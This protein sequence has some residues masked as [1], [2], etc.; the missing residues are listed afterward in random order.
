MRTM[1][2]GDVAVGRRKI[3]GFWRWCGHLFLQSSFKNLSMFFQTQLEKYVEENEVS[4]A[5]LAVKEAEL[6]WFN[7]EWGAALTRETGL[8]ATVSR[9]ADLLATS[10]A[11]NKELAARK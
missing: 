9:T 1:W 10:I 5:E 11:L 4:R 6:S 8:I 2:R 7:L 3:F